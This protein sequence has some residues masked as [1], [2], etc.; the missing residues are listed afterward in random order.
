M[1]Y[2]PRKFHPQR[3]LDDKDQQ[4]QPNTLAKTL[5]MANGM[6]QECK[7]LGIQ[8]IDIVLGEDSNDQHGNDAEQGP[9]L[10]DNLIENIPESDKDKLRTQKMVHGDIDPSNGL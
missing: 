10:K 1:E 5:A 3:R 4:G 9:K 8:L 6:Y 2:P 7:R